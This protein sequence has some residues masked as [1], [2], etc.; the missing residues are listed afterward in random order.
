[1]C[2]EGWQQDRR[3]HPQLRYLGA[4]RDFNALQRFPP[5]LLRNKFVQRLGG[6]WLERTGIAFTGF[7]ELLAIGTHKERELIKLIRRTRRQRKTL[8]LVTES[9]LLYFLARAQTK[10]QGAMAEVGVF[11]GSSARLLCEV[12]QDRP[13]HLFDTFE[14]LPEASEKDA[15]VHRKHQYACSLESVQNY[16]R[17]FDNVHFHKGLFPESAR[18]VSEQQYV[19]AHFDVDLYA[20]TLACLEYFYPRMIHGGVILSH[21]YGLLDGVR[22]AFTEFFADKPE[23]VIELPTTQCMVF[24]L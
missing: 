14:G 3:F 15:G 7:F 16:L 11:E 17:D 9:V 10:H 4:R 5:M 12:K 20:S 23:P 2:C 6:G 24:K 18:D 22:T 1:M 19:L 21:D 13:L 8:L